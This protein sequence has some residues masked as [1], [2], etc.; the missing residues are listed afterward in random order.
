MSTY[1]KYKSGNVANRYDLIWLEFN[2]VYFNFKDGFVLKSFER[3]LEVQLTDECLEV[4]GWKD[5]QDIPV[6]TLEEAIGKWQVIGQGSTYVEG[7]ELV[8]KYLEARRNRFAGV[9]V[10]NGL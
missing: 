9:I 7:E 8:S 10:G 1:E 5:A 6:I 2:G 4:M 3:N